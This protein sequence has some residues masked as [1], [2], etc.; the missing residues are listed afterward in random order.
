[1]FSEEQCAIIP[2]RNSRYHFRHASTGTLAVF[3]P[4]T[5]LPMSS[6]PVIY[7]RLNFYVWTLR[8]KYLKMHTPP[9]NKV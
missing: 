6:S 5:G 2:S 7:F 4:R 8:K 9:N 1:M 3:H